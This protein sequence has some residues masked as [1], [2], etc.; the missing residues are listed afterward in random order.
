MDDAQKKKKPVVV[1]SKVYPAEPSLLESLAEG[2]ETNDTR[3]QLQAIRK[4][5]QKSG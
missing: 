2:F 1:G 5:R 3:A 4:R